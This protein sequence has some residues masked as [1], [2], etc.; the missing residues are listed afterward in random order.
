MFLSKDHLER[1]SH[2]QEVHR[3]LSSWGTNPIS[4]AFVPLIEEYK[5]SC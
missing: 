1:N 4:D 3:F 2:S 5:D